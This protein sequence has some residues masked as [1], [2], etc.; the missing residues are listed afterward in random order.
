MITAFRRYL[1]TWVVRGFFLIMV[2]AF[3]LWGVGDVVRMVGTSPTWVAKVGDQTVESQQ[4]QEAYQRQMAQITAKLP[5]GQEPSQEVR[6]SV[7]KTTLQQLIGQAALDQELQRLHI[8]APDAAV[9]QSVFATPAFNGPSGQFDRQTFE[10]VLRNNGLTEPRFLDMVRGQLQ[11]RQLLEAVTAGAAASESMLHPL[12]ESQF[13]KRSA[14]TVEFPLAAAS[15]PSGSTEAELQRWYD[16]HPDQYSA[17]EYR[18][19]KAVVLSPETLAKDIPITEADLHAA[20]QQ[21]LSDYV[22]SEKRSAEVISV[23]EEAKANALATTWKSGADWGSMQKA[24]KEAGGTAIALDDATQSQF[25]DAGLAKTVFGAAQDTVT[26]PTKGALGWYLVRVVNISAGSTRSFAEVQDLLRNQVLAAKAADMMYDR[27]NKV[28]NAL[29]T[30]AD[31]DHMPD[32]LGLVGVAGTLDAEGETQAGTPA[33]IPGPPELKAALI[34]AAFTTPKSEPPQLVEVQTPSTGGSAYYAVSVEDII[35]PAVKPFDTVKQQVT[36]GWTQ[37]QRRRTEEAAATKLLTAVK[38]GQSLADA[39]TVAGVT[40]RRTPLVTREAR[41]EGMPAQLVQVLFGLK[42]GEP[43]MVETPDGFIVATPAEI[44][45]ADP[46]TD[47]A[48][49]DQLRTAVIRSIAGDLAS[50]F[51]DALRARAQPRINQAA[52]DNITGQPQ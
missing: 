39:A 10:T 18:R 12:Y 5:S 49:F 29:G 9:R 25:P 6:N 51:A 4:L 22:K 52:L 28:D 7:A 50:V 27:A 48:G 2:A 1:E 14:N 47:P 8:V 42:K 37:D 41:T 40:V 45:E 46:K 13:E 34:K 33:P 15:E 30:G 24:A 3:V 35:P 17:P 26:G 19:I 36:D 44:V 16:N 11:E 32:N 21:H 38:G 23:S 20:Y 43:T 31:L